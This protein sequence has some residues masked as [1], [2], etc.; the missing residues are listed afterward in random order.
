MQPSKPSCRADHVGSLL[1]PPQLLAA[2]AQYTEGRL[3]SEDLRSIEDQA[4]LEILDVQRQS[5]INIY[6][7]GEYRRHSWLTAMND[8]LDGFVPE[9][10]LVPWQGPRG[11]ITRVSSQVVG[12]KLRQKRRLH[13]HESAFLKEHARGPFK[14]TIPS[15]MMYVGQAYKPGVTD[16][17]YP[18]RAELRAELV[19][20]VRNEVRQL[21]EEGVP[22]IQIDDPSLTFYVDEQLREFLQGQGIDMA[23][24]VDEAIAA[25]NAAWSLRRT[26]GVSGR[27]IYVVGIRKVGGWPMAAMSRLRRSC[28]TRCRPTV[29]CSNMT[30][31]GRVTSHRCGLSPKVRR[32]YSVWSAP[33]TKSSS[34]KTLYYVALRRLPN[35][36]RS[37]NW[38]LA[39][40]V[41]LRPSRWGILSRRTTSN[42]NCSS[43]PRRPRRYGAG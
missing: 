8:A 9:N 7:D 37:S 11:G 25:D 39:R 16:K 34:R 27:Y 35:T 30:A 31:S 40:S 36:C 43:W 41:V 14:I 24:W 21:V 26:L 42:A 28:S 29:S 5:G 2:R 10:V 6:S 23:H 18:T 17:S 38:L 15:V 1:R 12:G 33:K 32:S 4:I 22:Y 19:N 13:G 20:I 3:R